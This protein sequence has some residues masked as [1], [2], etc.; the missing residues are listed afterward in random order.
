VRHAG[1]QQFV[2]ADAASRRSLIQALDGNQCPYD[3]AL[4]QEQ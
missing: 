1:A 2:Q 3:L 4:T